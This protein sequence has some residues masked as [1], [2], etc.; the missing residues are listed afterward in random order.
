[1]STSRSPAPRKASAAADAY[2]IRPAEPRDVEFLPAIES[3]AAVRFRETVHAEVAD[4]EPTAVGVFAA[5]AAAGRLWVAQLDGRVVGFALAEVLGGVAHLEELD[6]LPE[7]G[8][9]GL[10][11]KLLSAVYDWASACGCAE[12]TLTTFADVAWNRAFYESQGFTVMS[13]ERMRP[14]LAAR[15]REEASYG[16]DKN[17]VA[18]SRVIQPGGPGRGGA[19]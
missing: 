7:H 4:G 19:Q 13:G 9:R 18:M 16:L 2:L 17:R 8:R 10:G 6:V 5:A 3:R 12:L 15:M 11:A 1:M 14:E